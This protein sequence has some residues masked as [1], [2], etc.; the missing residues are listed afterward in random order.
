MLLL[1]NFLKTLKRRLLKVI[2][3]KASIVFH[4]SH[5]FVSVKPSADLYHYV[6][7]YQCFMFEVYQL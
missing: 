6:K 1:K 4:F 5:T 3:Q 2:A 7:L